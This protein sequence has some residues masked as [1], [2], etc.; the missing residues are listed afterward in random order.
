MKICCN[1]S[2]LVDFVKFKKKYSIIRAFGQIYKI[3]FN[4]KTSTNIL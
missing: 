3:L 4:S 2:I 1:F